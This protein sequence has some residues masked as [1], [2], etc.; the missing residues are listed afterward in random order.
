MFAGPNNGGTDNTSSL[1]RDQ[2]IG[3][4]PDRNLWE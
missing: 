4:T 2:T 3:S 1:L